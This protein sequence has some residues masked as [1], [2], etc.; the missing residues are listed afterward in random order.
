ML[1]NEKKCQTFKSKTQGNPR[2]RQLGVCGCVRACEHACLQQHKH[3]AY[4]SGWTTLGYVFEH[5][6]LV[7]YGQDCYPVPGG[8]ALSSL[9]EA[10]PWYVLC[11]ATL[12]AMEEKSSGSYRAQQL[13]ALAQLSLKNWLRGSAP[14][15]AFGHAGTPQRKHPQQSSS[16]K[17]E[18]RRGWSWSAGA[19]AVAP[20]GLPSSFAAACPGVVSLTLSFPWL[21]GKWVAGRGTLA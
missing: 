10:L 13:P 9:P 14:A 15:D 16:P 7:R 6:C 4:G 21:L 18:A 8:F 3:I 20:Q 2:K 17:A 1:A 11:R 5:F 12:V 19:L